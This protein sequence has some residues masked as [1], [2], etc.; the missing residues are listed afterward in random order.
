VVTDEGLMFPIHR[1][2]PLQPSQVST[3][4]LGIQLVCLPLLARLLA[5]VHQPKTWPSASNKY[6]TET[7]RWHTLV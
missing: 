4:G 2:N 5:L 1:S 7:D 6:R 3:A